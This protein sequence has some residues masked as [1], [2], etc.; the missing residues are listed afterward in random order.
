[1]G[2]SVVLEAPSLNPAEVRASKA[3][4]L[5]RAKAALEVGKE[6]L[7]VPCGPGAQR[8]AALQGVQVQ[9]T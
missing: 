6:V 9:G 7:G 2:E 4:Q 1:M 3:R 5:R 8:G